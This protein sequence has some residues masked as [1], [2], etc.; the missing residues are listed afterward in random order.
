MG[1]SCSRPGEVCLHNFCEGG[2]CCAAPCFIE[3]AGEAQA[4]VQDG[5][6]S[7]ARWKSGQVFETC[8][9]ACVSHTH[10]SGKK[11]GTRAWVMT[12]QDVCATGGTPYDSSSVYTLCFVSAL[13]LLGLACSIRYSRSKKQMPNE[14]AVVHAIPVHDW[15]RILPVAMPVQPDALACQSDHVVE[16]VV[17]LPV[18]TP[19]QLSP[20]QPGRESALQ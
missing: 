14:L 7:L 2:D 13:F 19:Q 17:M 20:D 6:A 5:Q 9:G 4:L 16:A 12:T 10:H 1:C 18:V 15:A 11:P 8:A 3:E